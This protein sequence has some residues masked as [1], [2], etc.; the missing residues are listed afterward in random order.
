MELAEIKGAG[1]A[2]VDQILHKLLFQKIVQKN[3]ILFTEVI[4]FYAQTLAIIVAGGGFDLVENSA[5]QFQLFAHSQQ[6]DDHLA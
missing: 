3:A 5:F 4:K 2:I 6:G 1:S